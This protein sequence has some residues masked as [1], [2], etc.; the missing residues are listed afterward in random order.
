MNNLADLIVYFEQLKTDYTLL[1]TFVF[2]ADEAVMNKLRADMTYPALILDLDK[3][4]FEG[5]AEEGIYKF[6]SVFISVVSWYENGDEPAKT[7]ETIK[8]EGIA[9]QILMRICIDFEIQPSEFE[10]FIIQRYEDNCIG[11]QLNVKLRSAS[12]ICK[13]DNWL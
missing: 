9:E 1:K 6:Y 13:D 3:K 8:T 7:T 10:M 12:T 11:W 5:N 2:G 4:F